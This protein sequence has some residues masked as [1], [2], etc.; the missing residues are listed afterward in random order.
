MLLMRRVQSYS[1][2]GGIPQMTFFLFR[3]HHRRVRLLRCLCLAPSPGSFRS[4]TAPRSSCATRKPWPMART[5]VWERSV[6]VWCMAHLGQLFV[7]WF[8]TYGSTCQ[9]R[10]GSLK[11]AL[12]RISQE[13]EFEQLWRERTAETEDEVIEL[14]VSFSICQML[15]GFVKVFPKHENDHLNL[16]GKHCG[17]YDFAVRGWSLKLQKRTGLWRKAALSNHRIGYSS[18]LTY[19]SHILA[20]STP[21]SL[22]WLVWNG[23]N[24]FTFST[25]LGMIYQISQRS[26][27]IN[28]QPV[29][30]LVTPWP[31]VAGCAMPSRGTCPTLPA[32]ILKSSRCIPIAPAPLA[33]AKVFFL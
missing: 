16:W 31:A 14:A 32:K 18:K 24:R 5:F 1:I 7:R 30:F 28:R 12:M 22:I 11:T 4:S 33:E 8:T 25:L 6:R 9:I 3:R 19:S 26:V 17:I 15:L 13:D 10:M 21:L 27:Y 29:P 20:K 23:L 2:I